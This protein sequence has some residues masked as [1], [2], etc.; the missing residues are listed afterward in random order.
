MHKS[1]TMQKRK[2]KLHLI[3]LE[4][5]EKGNHYFESIL[6]YRKIHLAYV[7][8]S[9]DTLRIDLSQHLRELTRNGKIL[10]IQEEDGK[11][12]ELP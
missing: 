7:R 6:N 10:M 4:A 5:I 2:D 8:K 12:Y 3:I 11:R 9:D 1:R